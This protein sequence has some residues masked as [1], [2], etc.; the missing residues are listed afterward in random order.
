MV[1]LSLSKP[2]IIDGFSDEYQCHAA[3]YSAKPNR[4][5]NIKKNVQTP[6][7]LTV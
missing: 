2:L 3:E 4:K 7:Q 5:I 1:S 6:S